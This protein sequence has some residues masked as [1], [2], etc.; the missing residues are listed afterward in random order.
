MVAALVL[1]TL[2]TSAKTP[3]S[4]VPIKYLVVDLQDQR[5]Y[6]YEGDKLLDSSRVCTGRGWHNPKAKRKRYRDSY[7]IVSKQGAKARSSIPGKYNLK[8]PYKFILSPTVSRHGERMHGFAKVPRRPSSHGCIRLPI[9]YAAKIHPWVE[10]GKTKVLV[11]LQFKQPTAKL[12]TWARPFVDKEV[13]MWSEA[14]LPGVPAT[15]AAA[16]N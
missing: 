7:V 12:L 5:I 9:S 2:I 15:R 13:P 3:E 14:T 11:K 16:A 8:T 10:P 4:Q 1:L 6:R